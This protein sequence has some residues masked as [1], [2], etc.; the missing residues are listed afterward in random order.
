MRRSVLVR[1]WG[2]PGA[3]APWQLAWRF[4]HTDAGAGTVHLGGVEVTL[5]ALASRHYSFK[6]DSKSPMTA[7]VD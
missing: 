2:L 5:N 7:E 3:W 4:L 1:G 6:Y